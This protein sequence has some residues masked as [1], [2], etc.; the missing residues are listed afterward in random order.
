MGRPQD[1]DG[2]GEDTEQER[3]DAADDPGSTL[4]E[5]I[6]AFFSALLVAAMIGLVLYQAITG[7]GARHPDLV[8]TV[9]E[10]LPQAGGF[11]VVYRVEN[12]GGATAAAVRV[13]GTLSHGD[14]IADEAEA[15][16]DYVAAHSSHRGG[17]IFRDDPAGYDLRLRV[18]G[19]RRP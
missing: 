14:A 18:T 19:Y 13:E 5:R 2:R 12:R 4:V 10:V 6:A 9:E 15:E 1:G 11:H 17:L 8:T 3:Q 16:I 7:A